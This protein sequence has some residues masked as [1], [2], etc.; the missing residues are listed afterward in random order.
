MLLIFLLDICYM[1]K[2]CSNRQLIFQ[3]E[4][5]IE[6]SLFPLRHLVNIEFQKIVN[7]HVICGNFGLYLQ[8]ALFK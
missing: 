1:A 8:T 5:T 2:T 4:H 3:F 7:L 6:F